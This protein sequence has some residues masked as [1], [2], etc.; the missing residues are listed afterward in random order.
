[1]AARVFESELQKI[2]KYS[3]S[4]IYKLFVDWTISGKFME[5]ATTQEVPQDRNVNTNKSQLTT[6][7]SC[8]III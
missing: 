1:M 2:R 5:D 8:V 4:Y 7:S 6:Y 3:K